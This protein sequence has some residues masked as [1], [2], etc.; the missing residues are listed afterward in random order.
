MLERLESE[1]RQRPP[2]K[3]E[4]PGESP[5]DA[6]GPVRHRIV[7]LTSMARLKLGDAGLEPLVPV[8]IV[9]LIEG[10]ATPGAFGVSLQVGEAESLSLS[11]DTLV[12]QLVDIADG[13]DGPAFTLKP[14]HRGS[15]ALAADPNTGNAYLVVVSEVLYIRSL[16]ATIRRQG[17][18]SSEQVVAPAPDDPMLAAITRAAA[19]NEALAASGIEDRIEGAIEFVTVT[20]DVLTVRRSWSQPLAVA[21]RGVTLEVGVPTGEVVRMGPLG[22]EL[23][24]LEVRAAGRGGSCRTSPRFSKR[25]V[26]ARRKKLRRRR[27]N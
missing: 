13:D 1:H 14:E 15:L 19:M 6:S 24:A 4:Q 9:P 8:E 2:W 22:L 16:E 26:A 11:V 3:P 7:S 20:D 17:K 5:F 23:P 18:P 10:A 25:A 12:E 27:R 21:V